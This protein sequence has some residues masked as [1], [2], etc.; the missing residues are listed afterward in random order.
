MADNQQ[1]CEL[2]LIASP[3]S[4][5]LYSARKIDERFKSYEQ[6][7]FQRDR[8]TCQFCGF[9][10]RL[11]QDIVNLDGDYTN[12]RLS[13]LVTAC[14]FCAQCFFVESVG[15]G[16]YGGGTLI[17][18]PE[19]TQAELNSLC[20][21]LFCAI[22][23]DTGYK[24]SAQNIYRSFKFRS[25]IVEEK[26]GEGTSDPA[27]FGQLMIDSGVKSEEIREKLFKNIRLL[28]SRAKFR[29]QIEKWAASALEEIAD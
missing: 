9:Q 17:Y 12:N 20:H 7:I 13:N 19:L 18:L 11:Y 6:K 21:V 23:N 26:F 27:I 5:R 1:R 8:Y 15:V 22:T 2:K 29:K 24:S 10:A 3:G 14:C 4:W 25:Q 16:G 28:P